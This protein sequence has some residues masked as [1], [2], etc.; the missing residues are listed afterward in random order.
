MRFLNVVLGAVAVT[1]AVAAP[2]TTSSNAGVEK[3]KSKFLFT[4]VNESGAEFG[5]GNL[6]GTLGTDYTWPVHS[7]IDVREADYEFLMVEAREGP[8]ILTD[9]RQTL[10]AKGFN[11]FRVP[12]LMYATYDGL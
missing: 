1:S 5:Q 7:T 10:T 9:N 3:R 4:G 12:I 8:I 2:T 6:P 11:I